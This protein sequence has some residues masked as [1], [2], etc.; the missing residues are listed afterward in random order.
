MCNPKVGTFS[1]DDFEQILRPHSRQTS[2]FAPPNIGVLSPGWPLKEKK[3]LCSNQISWGD[4]LCKKWLIYVHHSFCMV[5]IQPSL[6]LSSS[7]SP[8]YHRTIK[9]C[10]P[11]HW[12][13][14]WLVFLKHHTVS[15]HSDSF[16]AK[17]FTPNV[18]L[19]FV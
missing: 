10:P 16:D 7:S 12:P 18:R 13:S 2:W 1:N 14:R 19:K 17:L 11:T 4:I 3:S 8:R 5:N 9:S 15:T 6:P